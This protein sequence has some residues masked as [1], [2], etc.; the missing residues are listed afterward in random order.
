MALASSRISKRTLQKG[1]HGSELSCSLRV[2]EV[3]ETR[4]G[5]GNVPKQRQAKRCVPG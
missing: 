5:A 1:S 4:N 2:K 3:Q